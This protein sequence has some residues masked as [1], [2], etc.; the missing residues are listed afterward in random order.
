M[1]A[2]RDGFPGT[3]ASTMGPSD[4]RRREDHPQPTADSI[5]MLRLH[6]QEAMAKH[7]SK[8]QPHAAADFL[9]DVMEFWDRDV[10]GT[11]RRPSPTQDL[12]LPFESWYA[13][14]ERLN[15]VGELAAVWADRARCPPLECN[16]DVG[17]A[18][19]PSWGRMLTVMFPL[20][21]SCDWV[22]HATKLQGR[23]KGL[24]SRP[25]SSWKSHPQWLRSTADAEP[26]LRPL[27]R[28]W[29]EA[30]CARPQPP[31][32]SCGRF[33][34][35]PLPPSSGRLGDWRHWLFAA[36]PPSADTYV[37]DDGETPAQ[38]AALPKDNWRRWVSIVQTVL[39][40]TTTT[41]GGGGGLCFPPVSCH[42]S[43]WSWEFVFRV[44]NCRD[45]GE[46][47]KEPVSRKP[48]NKAMLAASPADL[49][50][51]FPPPSHC[52]LDVFG[53]SDRY[54]QQWKA[55]NGKLTWMA[56]CD[57]VIFELEPV[58]HF[59]IPI[60]LRCG[61]FSEFEQTFRRLNRT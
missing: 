33:G 7:R 2:E 29:R 30:C 60:V 17:K 27:A 3:D 42:C 47:Y 9:A 41:A 19:E 4:K 57:E 39:A 5:R 18:A 31:R 56:Y 6:L 52:E 45:P 59:N 43:F 16:C 25:P 54:P 35:R 55:E 38:S 24:P 26:S 12:L 48:Y 28:M 1:I 11:I 8:E 32:F 61:S 44:S 34:E 20:Q 23:I 37:L 13:D 36:N 49:F 10:F 53:R 50:R 21:P 40:A 22:M 14:F 51:L 46:M 15:C 58:R